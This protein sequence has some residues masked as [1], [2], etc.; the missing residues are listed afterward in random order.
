MDRAND[1][2][3]MAARY[4]REP[5]TLP[6]TFGGEVAISEHDGDYRLHV[7]AENGQFSIALSALDVWGLRVLTSAIVADRAA[8][9]AST[10]DDDPPPY[11][12]DEP[13]GCCPVHGNYWTDECIRCGR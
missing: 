5:H 3:E 4:P 10:L 6:L 1:I 9:F 8:E 13:L 11:T 12:G 2:A 7:Q